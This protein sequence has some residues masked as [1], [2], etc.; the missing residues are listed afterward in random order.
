MRLPFYQHLEGLANFFAVVFQR[1]LSLQGNDFLQSAGLLGFGYIVLKVL[2]GIGVRAHGE[3]EHVG[4]VVAHLAEHLQRHLVFLF[5]LGTEACNHVGGDGTVGHVAADGCNA[6]QIPGR[7]VVPVHQLQHPVAAALHGQ[8][9]AL[10]YIAVRGHH[11]QQSVAK[12]FGVGGG[13]P[14]PQQWTDAGHTVHQLGEVH[15]AVLVRIAI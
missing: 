12:V 1:Y 7:V 2:G 3:L 6:V 15:V 11:F 5:G 9:D 10:A 13:K 8:V 4:I 14:H